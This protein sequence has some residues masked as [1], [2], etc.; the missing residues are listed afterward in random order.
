MWRSARPS[1]PGR[2][3]WRSC[4]GRSP[5]R[6]WCSASGARRRGI[7]RDPPAPCPDGDVVL[8]IDECLAFW[9]GDMPQR[10]DGE[11]FVVGSRK[12]AS[13]RHMRPSRRPPLATPASRP[14]RSALREVQSTAAGA[15][16]A[17][18]LQ[19]ARRGRKPRFRR[20]SA[21]FPEIRWSSRGA[22]CNRPR[23]RAGRPS[24]E[25]RVRRDPRSR[26]RARPAR[27]ARRRR[28]D[29]PG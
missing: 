28:R 24:T 5:S 11:R 4:P 8:E 12:R 10:R 1:A 3:H 7:L 29:E 2:S 6:A 26:P 17:M 22:G 23:L 14:S 13:C 27:R 9:P 19:A 21:A 15:R 25:N 16:D 20:A 18:L